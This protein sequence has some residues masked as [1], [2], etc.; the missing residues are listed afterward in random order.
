[1]HAKSLNPL[2]LF[3]MTVLAA[4]IAAGHG[5][6][7]ELVLEEVIVTAF[8]RESVLMETAAAVSAFDGNAREELG[9]NNALD[10]AAH[11]PSLNQKEGI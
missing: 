10:L 6:A 8:K 1:M 4:S 2:R 11:T 7:Q 9:I 5:L 3:P